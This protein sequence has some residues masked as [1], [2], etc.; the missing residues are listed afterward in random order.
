MLDW[1]AN[2]ANTLFPN[3]PAQAHLRGKEEAARL[4]VEFGY[5]ISKLNG[6]ELD[7]LELCALRVNAYKEQARILSDR[8]IAQQGN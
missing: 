6:R 8:L 4:A 2:Q 7:I 1:R 3:A 5:D